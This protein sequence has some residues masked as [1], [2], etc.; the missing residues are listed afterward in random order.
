MITEEINEARSR[1]TNLI[2]ELRSENINLNIEELTLEEKRKLR[3]SIRN[4]RVRI[5]QARWDYWEL[6][7]KFGS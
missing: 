6:K 5:K 3:K 2:R 4:I 7:N 1:I